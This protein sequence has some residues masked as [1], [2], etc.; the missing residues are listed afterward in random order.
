MKRLNF[1]F[2]TLCLATLAA[3]GGGGGGGASSTRT[4]PVSGGGGADAPLISGL[5]FRQPTSFNSAPS[6]ETVSSYV[7][8]RGGLAS[9]LTPLI[10]CSGGATAASDAGVRIEW[11][12]VATGASGSTRASAGC[13]NSGTVFG[14]GLRTYWAVDDIRLQ[15]GRN[16]IRFL[17]YVDGRLRGEDVV[18]IDRTDG[19]APVVS[20]RYP[21]A[22]EAGVPVNRPV[23]VRF[24]EPMRESSLDADRLEL[25]AAGGVAVSGSHVYNQGQNAWV[26]TPA[27]DLQP[28][29]AYEVRVD[30]AVEDQ[31]GVRLGEAQT[32]A[33]STGEARDEQAPAV[34]RRWPDAD[35]CDCASPSTEIQVGFAEPMD[36]GAFPPDS[37]SLLTA[38]G[39][40]VEARLEYRVNH[41]ALLPEA[42]LAARTAYRVQISAGLNDAAGNAAAGASS[43]VFRTGTD[44]AS[45]E[46][47]VAEAPPFSLGSGKGVWTGQ[48]LFLWGAVHRSANV[49]AEPSR[50]E[51][52]YLGRPLSY[53]PATDS[54]TE[55]AFEIERYDFDQRD[56]VPEPFPELREAPS[57]VWTGEEV[58]LFGGSVEGRSIS[59]GGAY[60]PSTDSWRLISNYWRDDPL[61]ERRPAIFIAEHSTV[62]TGAEMIVW[63]GV[64]RRLGDAPI[65]RGWRYEPLSGVWRITG[66]GSGIDEDFNILPDLDPLAP[67]PRREPLAVWSGSELILWGGE[68][69]SGAP[70]QDGGLYDPVSNSWRAM[71]NLGSPEPGAMKSIAHLQGEE[72]LV[73]NG[74][75]EARAPAAV[76][77]VEMHRYS[78]A[79]DSWQP[80]TA[81]WEPSFTGAAFEVVQA[82]DRL[83]A[84][85]VTRRTGRYELAGWVQTQAISAYEY[86]PAADSWRRGGEIQVEGLSA[87]PASF[88]AVW[89]DGLLLLFVGSELLIYDPED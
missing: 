23:I 26:F 74:G 35:G 77:T 27:G 12:N 37:V 14:V 2:L 41:L 21:A 1:F 8:F 76:R 9:V 88:E 85:G 6:Y 52:E 39:E 34:T 87:E 60:D 7:D 70:L 65:N 75:S 13:V 29:T 20:H 57:L 55:P 51:E 50:C 28:N 24:N 40:R 32:W 89:A 79:S 71:S 53:D 30:A 83:I 62:W 86:D 36:P 15:L 81:G 47:R 67:A 63:G 56:Y 10:D 17:S 45:G 80:S 22:E 49:C 84:V 82:D 43:W 16:E 59:S 11:E 31:W 46:W 58:L 66:T 18:Y 25:T 19:T 54:W 64:H 73:W 69:E 3:C 33:F 48:S 4:G 61:G 44:A 78:T 38:A 42:P 68:G 5:D 72:M